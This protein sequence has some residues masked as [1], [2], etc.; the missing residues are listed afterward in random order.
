MKFFHFH[1][2]EFHVDNARWGLAE[3]NPICKIRVFRYN[4]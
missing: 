4:G 2:A 1:I 3:K